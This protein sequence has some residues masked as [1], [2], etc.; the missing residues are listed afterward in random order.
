M[1]GK[2]EQDEEEKKKEKEVPLSFFLSVLPL[3]LYF[4]GVCPCGGGLRA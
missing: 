1:R 2:M 3:G 4:Y